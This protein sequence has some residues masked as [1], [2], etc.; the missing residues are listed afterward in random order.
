M[1]KKQMPINDY[2]SSEIIAY[3]QLKPFIN[4]FEY[5]ICLLIKNGGF[6]SNLNVALGLLKHAYNA[7]VVSDAQNIHEHLFLKDSRTLIVPAENW[8]RYLEPMKDDYPE[9]FYKD[10]D[11]LSFPNNAQNLDVLKAVTNKLMLLSG[12]MPSLIDASKLSCLEDLV[13]QNRY[14]PLIDIEVVD[15]ARQYVRSN[16]FLQ[17]RT[18]I[19]KEGYLIQNGKQMTK[20]IFELYQKSNVIVF[21]SNE[22]Y[23]PVEIRDFKNENK[24]VFVSA[25]LTPKF[26]GSTTRN[27]SRR[28]QNRLLGRRPF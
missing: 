16:I 26:F 27:N 19:I 13:N 22:N 6:S 28:L 15:P 20:S 2:A 21:K 11:I 9:Y 24:Y 3:T 8:H 12:Y 17:N 4:S 1:E 25:G 14:I 5:N 7:T 18:T 23:D 10:K